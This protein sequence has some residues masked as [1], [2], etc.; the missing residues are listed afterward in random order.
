MTFAARATA[1]RPDDGLLAAFRKVPTSAISDNLERL[2]GAV[3]LRPFHRSGTMCGVALTVHTA[4]GDNLAVHQ[5]LELI[6][7][8]DVLVVDGGGDL[9]RALVGEIIKTIAQKRGAAGMVINGAIRD[10]TAFRGDD[11]PCFACAA[12]HRGP[13]KKGPGK[14]NVPVSIGGTVIEP[15]DIV[16]GDEDGIVA[17]SPVVAESLLAAVMLQLRKE[18][19]ILQSVHEGRYAGAYG[20]ASSAVTP[21]QNNVDSTKDRR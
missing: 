7:P 1:Q 15:G 4:A 17:F 13:Y 10:A 18:A 19:E 20:V 9:G 8:G 21:L 11:F 3:G 2:P 14:I 5:S 12:F 6:Q 16:V